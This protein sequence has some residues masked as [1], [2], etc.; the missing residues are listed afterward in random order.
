MTWTPQD[1]EAAT[2]R[3]LQDQR[4]PVRRERNRRFW[5]TLAV[6]FPT[7]LAAAA[8]MII[9]EPVSNPAHTIMFV[10]ASVVFGAAGFIM[11]WRSSYYG[12]A[13]EVLDAVEDWRDHR[14]ARSRASSRPPHAEA[15]HQGDDDE[16]T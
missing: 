4:Q 10:A 2:W 9:T 6:W 8:V 11:L 16:I 5:R 3:H 1:R 7:M 14:E 12:L 13:R 15:H